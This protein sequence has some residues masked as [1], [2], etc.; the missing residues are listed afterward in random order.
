MGGG[1]WVNLGTFDFDKGDNLYNC[2]MLTN[3]SRKTWHGNGRCREV[4]PVAW[5]IS[6][7]VVSPADIPGPSRGTLLRPMGRAP[8]DVYGGREAP[9][10]M[11]T[12]SIPGRACS[13][14]LAGGSVYV[15]TLEGKKVPIELSLAV[16]SDAGYAKD[17]AGLIVHWPS[18]PPTSTT[19]TGF[20]H[21]QNVVKTA[22]RAVV[23]RASHATSATIQGLG[24]RYLWDRNYSETRCPRCRQPIIETMSHQNFPDMRRGQDPNFKFDLARSLYKTIVRYVNEMHG[25]L[26]SSPPLHPST[27]L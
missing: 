22:G 20:G 19:P 10:T 6:H 7:E 1:T 11:P 21:L 24:T 26:R 3:Q 2:V 12:T 15:P 25:R 17:G 5:A 9:T 14:W 18:A 23:C 8:Y 16:H 13:H 27:S 4:R